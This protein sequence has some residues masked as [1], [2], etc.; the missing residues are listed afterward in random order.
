MF[1]SKRRIRTGSALAAVA[2]AAVT[3]ALPTGASPAGAGV[4]ARTTT[5][6]YDSF[7]KPG[8]YTLNDYAAKWSN[9]Y[10]PGEMALN[11][12]R[13]FTGGRFNVSAAPFQTAYDYSVYDHL[14]YIAISNQAFAV[15]ASGAVEIS[16]TIK[17]S[18]PGTQPG[19]IIHGTYTATGAPYAQPTI[20]GQQ[21]GAVMNVVDFATGQ[22]FDWFVSGSKAFTLIERLPSNVTGNTSDTSSP[23][24]VGRQKLYTQIIRE[25]PAA[26]GVTHRVSI[27][28][29]RNAAGSSVDYFLDGALVSHVVR[30][31]VPLDAQGAPYTGTYPSLGA[32]EELGQKINYLVIGH[33]LFSL[34]DAFPFQHPE[35]PELSVSIPISERA[36]GQGAIATFDD[37]K[38]KTTTK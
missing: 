11:D 3:L 22:L 38:V 16:S 33:G 10:G 12:T 26:P 35:A 9:P 37:F 21:A 15:P 14:K 32:G 13:N 28:F 34:L 30:V 23:D 25:V 29:S 24:Y 7:S 19:R 4:A 18:T 27:R 1:V 31:G 2:L 36:F 17:A 5:A 8:G 6:I 20:E